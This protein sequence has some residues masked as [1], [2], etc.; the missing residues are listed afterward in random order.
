[1]QWWG[2]LTQQ[3]QEIAANAMKDVA[4]KAVDTGKGKAAGVAGEAAGK[5]V[6]KTAGK[7]P[8]RKRS[9]SKG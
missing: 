6:K 7:T 1:M 5:A 9:A 3:L 4:Q 8:S 2:A